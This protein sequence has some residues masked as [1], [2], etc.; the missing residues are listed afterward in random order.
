MADLNYRNVQNL[1]ARIDMNG[2]RPT[3]DLSWVTWFEPY[4]LLYLGMFLRHH[5]RDDRFFDVVYPTKAEARDYLTSQNFWERFRFTPNPVTDRSLLRFT[6]STS[7][8][9]IIDLQNRPTQADEVGDR[10][11]EILRRNGVGVN[12]EEVTVAVSELVQNFVEHADEGL[13]AMMAQYYPHHKNVR[14]AIGDCGVGIR[15]SLLRSGQYPGLANVSHKEAI[16][17]ALQ[18]K[19]TSKAEGGMGFCVVADIVKDQRAQMFLSS[20]DGCVYLDEHGRLYMLD[21]PYD[22]PGVQ[23]ELCFPER[24]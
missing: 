4:A 23:A 18:P 5:N 2:P 13:A 20:N 10:L 22:L 17:E 21:V 7:F 11:R 24:R 6:S 14:I 9:D 3:I 16:V 12:T 8:N 1:C 19:V 15:G